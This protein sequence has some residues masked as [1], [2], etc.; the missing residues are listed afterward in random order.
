M[1]DNGMCFS[2][3]NAYYKDF[4]S[5]RTN[6]DIRDYLELGLVPK[7]PGIYGRDKIKDIYLSE[8]HPK[9]KYLFKTDTISYEDYLEEH[10]AP[11]I[12]ALF[13]SHCHLDHIRNMLF[14]HPDIPVYCSKATKE[15]LDIICDLSNDNYLQYCYPEIDKYSNSATFPGTP[16]KDK[17]YVDR[18]INV[19][20]PGNPLAIPEGNPHFRVKGHPVDHS[21]PGAMAFEI[22][23]NDG[24]SIIYTGDIRFHGNEYGRKISNS[25][26]KHIP[27]NPDAWITEG[28]RIDDDEEFSEEDVYVNMTNLLESDDELSEKLILAT[29]PWKS[30]SRFKT[31]YRVSKQLNRTLVIQPKLAYTL[32]NLQNFDPLNIKNVLANENLKI[33]LPRKYSMIYSKADYTRTKYNLSYNTDWDEEIELYSSQYGDDIL[34]K[35]YEIKHNPNEYVLHLNFYDL[36]ELIDI[37]PPRG[38]YYFNLKTEPFDERGEI[39]EQVLLNWIDRFGLQYERDEYH[40]SGH[41]PGKVLREMIRKVNPKRIFPIHTERPDLFSFSNA[42]ADIEKGKR[43]VI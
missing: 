20:E 31:L 34:L 6:N 37:Q 5:P 12:S 1:L 33:Y 16:H 25:F 8:A 19:I 41:A 14:M 27:H 13:L 24:K 32:H 3:E 43:Y 39:E 22:N 2:K 23:T 40:A 17:C 28:T 15:L 29:F 9:S 36:N 7:I 35:A 42:E 38:S 26:L 21:V 18:T 4:L 30:I 11:Y 10:G